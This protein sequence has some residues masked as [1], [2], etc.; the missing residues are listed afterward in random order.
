MMDTK[1]VCGITA[2]LATVLAAG[3]APAQTIERLTPVTDAML[4]NPPPADWLMA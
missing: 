3:G 4:A 1:R 2:V